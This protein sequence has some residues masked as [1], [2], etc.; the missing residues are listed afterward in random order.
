MT[1]SRCYP[2][3]SGYGHHGLR[4]CTPV[5]M[6]VCSNFM[7][8]RHDVLS[9]FDGPLID[10]YMRAAHA[11][12]ME[13]FP[14][15]TQ[16]VMLKT[17]LPLLGS[18]IRYQEVAGVTHGSCDPVE[19]DDLHVC[20]LEALIRSRLQPDSCNSALLVT[21]GAHTTA[22]LFDA[23]TGRAYHFDPL[24]AIMREVSATDVGGLIMRVGGGPGKAVSQYDGLLMSRG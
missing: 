10:G 13:R 23:D 7:R 24:P 3:Q 22:L 6:L 8:G 16:P 12:Y 5:C 15:T 17:L 14:D 9:L 19:V 20:G 11:L 18:G 1:A 2:S 4:I 21:V